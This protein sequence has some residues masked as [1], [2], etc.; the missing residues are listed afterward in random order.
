VISVCLPTKNA[1]PEFARYLRAWREQKTEEEVELVVVDSG[2]RDQTVATARELGARVSLIPPETFNHGET[3]N[4]LAREAR[5]DLLVFTVQ[6]ACPAHDRVLHE[7]TCWMRRAP[8]L[9]AVT[10]LQ[11]PHAHADAVARWEVEAHRAIIERGRTLKRYRWRDPLR[12]DFLNRLRNVAFDNVCSA[13]RRSVWEKFPFARVEFAE[14]L[15]WAVRVLR[16]G[17]SLLRNPAARVHHSHNSA[18][19]QRLKRAFVSRRALNRIF[20]MP[21]PGTPWEEKEAL[22]EIGDYLGLLEGARDGLARQPEPVRRLRLP[23]TPGH[24]VRGALRRASRWSSPCRTSRSPMR[25]QAASTPPCATCSTSTAA[26]RAWKRKKRRC[27]SACRCWVIFWRIPTPPRPRPIS[28]PSG[29]KNWPAHS[30]A[31]S[32]PVPTPALS[33]PLRPSCA[34]ALERG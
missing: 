5:G 25:W 10:G 23:T 6:D 4:L 12:G 24:W 26:C 1:G 31:G 13:L 8:Q 17:H 2:S 16:A 18:P 14:D 19:Y 30:P 29:W 32:S 33:P 20:E 21:S 3:R 11:V 34:L 7:L 28:R 9:A 22:S 15:D 27:S